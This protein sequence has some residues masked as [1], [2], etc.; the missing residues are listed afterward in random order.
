MI[1]SV[2]KAIAILKCFTVQEPK[3]SVTEIS[4]RLGMGKSTV[5]RLLATLAEDRLVQEDPE[6]GHYRL[7]FGL[8][9]LAGVMLDSIDLRDVAQL[10]LTQLAA[11]CKETVNLSVIDAGEIVNVSRVVSR[12][13]IAHL[14]WIGRRTPIHCTAAGKALLAY[15]GADAIAAVLA[16]PL[17]ALTPHTITDPKV[18]ARQLDE[19]RQKGYALANEELE[20]GLVSVAAPI[21]N[22][23]HTPVAA[24][25]ISGPSFRFT[26]ERLATHATC[27]CRTAAAISEDLG[28]HS[29]RRE[30]A[31]AA[32]AKASPAASGPSNGRRQ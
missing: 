7:G 20:F 15:Q 28:Y 5:S 6:T 10:H 26:P 27:V 21:W 13:A 23:E 18:L 29:G 25:A 12:Q 32:C 4:R 8:V 31:T 3:L 14:G 30:G 11:A 19:I 16:R 1:L 24:V 22:H 2:H 9:E 17:I